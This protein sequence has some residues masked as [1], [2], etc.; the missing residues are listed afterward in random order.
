MASGRDKGLRGRRWSYTI[1]TVTTQAETKKLKALSDEVDAASSLFK[2]GFPILQEY[3]FATRDADPLFVCLAGGSEKLLK[4]TLGLHGLEVDGEWPN[5]AVMRTYGHKIRD[6]D[7]NVRRL[8]GGRVS[9]S[10]APGYVRQLLG[11]VVQDPYIDR[12]LTTLERYAVRGRFYNLDYL[13]EQPQ[14]EASPAQLWEEL[15]QAITDL[16]P[17]LL[18]KLASADWE[19]ARREI[20]RLIEAS[21]RQWCELIARSWMTGVFGEQAKRWSFQLDLHQGTV[22]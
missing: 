20:N 7:A 19:R 12:V 22:R 10:T 6:L 13:G 9:H 16:R 2:H 5:S 21:V 1:V 17:D 4:L 8:I 11:G 18:A 3:K 15:H 14:P